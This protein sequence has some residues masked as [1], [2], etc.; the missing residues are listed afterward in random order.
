MQT[1]EIICANGPKIL[2]FALSAFFPRC[3]KRFFLLTSRF[4]SNTDKS[5]QFSAFLL[6]SPHVS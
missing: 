3:R 5:A 1:D 4:I 6:F 2:R